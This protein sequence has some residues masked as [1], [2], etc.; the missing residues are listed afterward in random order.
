MVNKVTAYMVETPEHKLFLDE[1]DALNY[2][3]I[4]K[5]EKLMDNASRNIEEGIRP[6]LEYLLDFINK[7]GVMITYIL[8][9]L[10]EENL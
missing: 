1:T 4:T 8:Q 10:L 7:N 6:D 9:T 2:E 5:L 3:I